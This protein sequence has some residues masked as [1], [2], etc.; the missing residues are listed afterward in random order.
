MTSNDKSTV[1]M[2]A[3]AVALEKGAWELRRRSGQ[4]ITLDEYRAAVAVTLDIL[5]KEGALKFSPSVKPC[6]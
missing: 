4:W 6:P 1:F 2:D 5:D 3:H